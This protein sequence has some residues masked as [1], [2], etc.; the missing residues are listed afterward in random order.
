FI[1][2]II[3]SQIAIQLHEWDFSTVIHAVSVRIP[4][5]YGTVK[6]HD[7]GEAPLI[8]SFEFEHKISDKGKEMNLHQS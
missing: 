5:S 8:F 7:G 2:Y 1:P 4:A 3:V 6:C